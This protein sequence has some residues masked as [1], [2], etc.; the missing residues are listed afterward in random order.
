MKINQFKFLVIILLI[1]LAFAFVAKAY[2]RVIE[3]SN[4]QTVDSKNIAANA[5][6]LSDPTFA[7]LAVYGNLSTPKEID[8][9]SFIPQLS[10]SIPIEVLVPS[11]PSN[12][13]FRPALVIIG[14]DIAE[15]PNNSLPFNLPEGY[16]AR[17]LYAPEGSREIFYESF[18]LERL[19]RGREEKITVNAG[20]TY[21]VVIFEPNNHT[22][23]YSLGL[24]I[25]ENLE[26][27]SY[28]GL[29]KNVL[30]I[31][32]GLASGRNT[33]FTDFFGLLLL[34]IGI[35]IGFGASAV[36]FILMLISR[37][38]ELFS[39]I[40]KRFV[41]I[42][43]VLN[44][45]GLIVAV[46]GAMITYRISGLSGVATF[47]LILGGI[48]LISNGHF[49]F[50]IWKYNRPY[51]GLISQTVSLVCWFGCLCFLVWYILVLR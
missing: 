2:Q 6:S 4:T 44:F 49:S 32:L 14:K 19:Y 16:K 48:L 37:T 13:D 17:V 50:R 35:V 46:I 45:A 11:R 30:A 42:C 43:S 36:R 51:K 1:I 3:S 29:I 22:G 47:Q 15:T 23:D 28:F 12:E 25:K 9:Y 10:E 34:M 8:V 24:G 26:K 20:Q 39:F 31:K 21:F 5:T 40:A 27:V 41:T 7:S 18:S 33:S 38:N